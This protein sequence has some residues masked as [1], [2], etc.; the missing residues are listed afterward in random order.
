VSR[1]TDVLDAVADAVIAEAEALNRLDAVAGDGD[2]GVTMTTA[3]RPGASSSRVND[4][5]S[6]GAI[7]STS[8]NAGEIL[9][10]INPSGS[11]S[12]VRVDVDP[13]SA[14]MFSHVVRH[15][16]SQAM[17]ERGLTP[18]IGTRSAISGMTC[19]TTV[20]RSGSR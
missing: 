6:V 7:P 10:P 14:A 17:N 4:R 9:A 13:M 16:F 19:W 2:L 5:P 11:P 15:A 20:R 3:F 18:R 8:N 1:L 12:P